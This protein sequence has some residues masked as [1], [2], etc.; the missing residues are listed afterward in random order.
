MGGGR[1]AR[2]GLVGQLGLGGD[3]HEPPHLVLGA[4]VVALRA[5]EHL[6]EGV[7][8]ALRGG[9]LVGCVRAGPVGVRAG[10]G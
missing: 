10:G 6:G 3:H 5:A 9:A 1:T 4:A 7:G 8:A 2:T